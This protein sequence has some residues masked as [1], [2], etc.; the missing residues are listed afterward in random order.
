MLEEV[1][2]AEYFTEFGILPP[3]NTKVR[4]REKLVGGRLAVET[5]SGSKVIGYIP[6]AYNYLRQCI[7]KGWSYVGVVSKSSSGKIP[8]VQVNLTSSKK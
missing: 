7:S 8:K 4:I 3:E 2:L 5:A 1:A 6:T